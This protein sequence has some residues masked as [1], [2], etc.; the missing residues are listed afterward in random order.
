MRYKCNSVISCAEAAFLNLSLPITSDGLLNSVSVFPDPENTRLAVKILL[1]CV[2]E[3]DIHASEYFI[4][5]TSVKRK[6][7]ATHL[8]M[9]DE[10]FRRVSAKIFSC[11]PT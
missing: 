11:L 4:C 6:G 1:L 3:L 7:G 5:P 2:I 10:N 8:S 9:E